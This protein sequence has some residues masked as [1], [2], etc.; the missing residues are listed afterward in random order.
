MRTYDFA[1]QP[2]TE[3][4]YDL[5]TGVYRQDLRRHAPPGSLISPD[6]NHAVHAWTNPNRTVRLYLTR[7]TDGHTLLLTSRSLNAR[8]LAGGDNADFSADNSQFALI[9]SDANELYEQYRLIVVNLKTYTLIDVPLVLPDSSALARIRVLGWSADGQYLGLVASTNTTTSGRFYFWVT[10][11]ERLIAGD[12]SALPIEGDPT[13]AP[14]GHLM[15]AR[16]NAKV[17]L[18]ILSPT[19]GIV[20]HA[21][22]YFEY[23]RW[24]ADGRQLSAIYSDSEGLKAFVLDADKLKPAQPPYRAPEGFFSSSGE[25]FFFQQQRDGTYQILM[26]TLPFDQPMRVP[27]P[28]SP[29]RYHLRIFMP[30]YQIWQAGVNYYLFRLADA[31]VTWLGQFEMF[32]QAGWL[33]SVQSVF[34]VA[35]RNEQWV[36]GIFNP[37]TEQ[38]SVAFALPKATQQTPARAVVAPNGRSAVVLTDEG[39]LVGDAESTYNIGQS[40]L[41]GLVWSPDSR[42]FA[43]PIQLISAPIRYVIQIVDTQGNVVQTLPPQLNFGSL[44]WSTCD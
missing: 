41:T 6:G 40:A 43:R 17:G 18:A 16:L 24:H 44:V 13:W 14:R 33:E 23:L 7:Q 28:A 39:L 38:H 22:L 15:A 19:E 5:K 10:A 9:Y 37:M 25:H 1:G 8:T 36:V 3:T 4:L 11:Q 35:R 30:N 2:I 26:A 27:F 12:P 29:N 32:V 21:V 31:K 20:N 42:Y 34:Y